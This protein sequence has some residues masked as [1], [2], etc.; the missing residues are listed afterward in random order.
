M[1]DTNDSV[2]EIE[3]RPTES[4]LLTLEHRFYD[5]EGNITFAEEPISVQTQILGNSTLSMPELADRAIESVIRAMQRK[6]LKRL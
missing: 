1:A 6:A 5:E 3:L 4:Y 2:I